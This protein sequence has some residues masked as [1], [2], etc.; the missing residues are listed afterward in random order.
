MLPCHEENDKTDS[1]GNPDGGKRPYTKNGF[2]DATTDP[3]QIARW[4]AAWPRALVGVA[5]PENVLVIDLDTDD[6][7]ERLE[8][9]TG[10]LP[11]TLTART[12]REGGGTHLYYVAKTSD[13]IQSVGIIPDVDLRLHPKGYVIAPPSVHPDTGTPYTW[14]NPGTPIAMLPEHAQAALYR[15]Q[16]PRQRAVK[17]SDS[18]GSVFATMTGGT[19]DRR[20]DGVLAWQARNTYDGTRNA[21]LNKSAFMLNLLGKG[22]RV[23]EAADIARAAGLDEREITRTLESA[24]NG[25]AKKAGGLQ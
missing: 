12:G 4:W 16:H 7:R 19:L 20:A 11:D 23:D 25:A 22:E 13:L 15:L 6:A 3:A 18:L 2:K 21:T 14:V 5:L 10:T 17:P 8:E 24:R 1:E 9:H